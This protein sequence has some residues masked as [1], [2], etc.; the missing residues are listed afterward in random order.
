MLNRLKQFLL[1]KM[2]AQKKKLLIIIGIT[3]SVLFVFIALNQY[4]V[5]FPAALY[6]LEQRE[7]SDEK[8]V[9]AAC[10]TFY[11]L[12]QELEKNDINIIKTAFT[13]ESIYYLQNNEAD[14]IIAGRAL[15]PGEPQLLYEII[16]SGY[17]FIGKEEFL[18]QEKE[19]NNYDFFTDLSK[20]AILEKFPYIAKNR[21]LEIENVYD[22]LDYGIIVTSI[23]NT[24][25]SKSQIVHIY[26][27]D[28]SRHRFSRAPIIYYSH[29]SDKNNVNYIKEIT[30]K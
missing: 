29:L 23:E 13:T 15:K 28:G 3:V 7:I 1:L 4:A 10:P 14:L 6:S 18:I 17:S 2:K 20:A 24:D 8:I 11:Y 9:V 16:G 5:Y 21:I 19:M 25:Y 12:L 26:K 22:Y 27:E 30:V